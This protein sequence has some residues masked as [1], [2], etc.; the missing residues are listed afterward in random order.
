MV[1][2]G[3]T[4]SA[5]GRSPEVEVGFA[6]SSRQPRRKKAKEFSLLPDR[7]WKCTAPRAHWSMII[8][9]SPK[10][11]CPATITSLSAPF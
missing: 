9:R 4:E 2:D 10:H 5:P 1:D 7:R 8:I 11:G 3:D 6:G